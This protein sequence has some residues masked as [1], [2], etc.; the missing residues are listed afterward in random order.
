MQPSTRTLVLPVLGLAL[1]L[2]PLSASGQS[3]Q[4]EIQKL[5]DRDDLSGLLRPDLETLDVVVFFD[6]V[7]RAVAA[8]KA[9]AEA[10]IEATV[11]E[12][13]AAADDRP[14]QLG[15]ASSLPGAASLLDHADFA[16]LL[17]LAL[18]R[19]LVDTKEGVTTVT[20]SP[21]SLLGLSRPAVVREQIEYEKYDALRRFGL[22]VSS[23][24]KGE[25]LDQD[26]DG[27]LDD[28]LE[29]KALDDIVSAELEV[30]LW[31]DRDPRSQRN[32]RRVAGAPVEVKENGAKA[33]RSVVDLLD[34]RV[35]AL[36]DLAS[37]DVQGAQER[38]AR[39]IEAL[40]RSD[41]QL[42]EGEV[43]R[44]IPAKRELLAPDPQT[45]TL[46]LSGCALRSDFE[47]W[48][49]GP[50][51]ADLAALRASGSAFQTAFDAELERVAQGPLLTAFYGVTERKDK[52][53]PA[54]Q[55]GGLRFEWL[56]L[57]AN[58][59][60]SR[61]ESLV[62]G[63]KDVERR[64]VAAAYNWKLFADEGWSKLIDKP[65][66]ASF[67]V[68]WENFRHDPTAKHDTIASA[69][70][71]L[72][73]VVAKGVKVP[74]SITYANHVD[75]LTGQ[76]EVRGHIGITYDL[77]GLFKPQDSGTMANLQRAAAKG[78]R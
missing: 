14:K 56:Q 21:F 43:S 42:A 19:D 37:N 11:G 7:Q 40:F 36:Q 64:K 16:T 57:T 51:K 10:P 3:C 35:R 62:A 49:E 34:D 69:S 25:K 15:A 39:L 70:L 58:A 48:R 26:G 60:V 2:F 45:Q 55:R 22:K 6:E 73:L 20:L 76:D 24:G 31:G 74:I 32:Y 65:A 23:G 17:G 59:E 27:K 13:L 1:S 53:G 28:P 5:Q 72:E 67:S 68:S 38:R 9:D 75:Q 41:A 18:D 50:G 78:S 29:A 77:S 61:T 52:F 30:R 4:K 66:D 46:P 63:A 12:G 33:K 8:A 47:A 44:V 54:S 71:K